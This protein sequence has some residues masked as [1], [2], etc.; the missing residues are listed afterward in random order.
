MLRKLA[1]SLALTSLAWAAPADDRFAQVAGDFLEGYLRNNPE[2]ATVLGDHRYDGDWSD[3][4]AA[5]VER[6]LAFARELLARLEALPASEL[7]RENAVDR[8]MLIH[9]LRGQ[10]WSTNELKEYHWNPLIY[11]PGPAI[12][13]IIAR[14]YAPLPQRLE[15]VASRLENLPT[16]LQQARAQLDNPPPIHCQTAIAQNTGTIAFLENDLE[17]FLKQAPEKRAR[18]E[19]A[20]RL[21]VQA[22]REYG[23]WLEKDL[24]PRSHGDFRLGRERWRKKLFFTLESSL[25]PEELQARAER[26][27]VRTHQEMTRVARPL[28]AQLLHRSADK[29]SDSQVCRAVLHKLAESRPD[30]AT[31]VPLAGE[32]LKKATAFVADHKLV[33]LPQEPCQIIEM[34]EFNRGVAIAYCDSPG[35]LEKG[36][37]TYYAIAPTP[38]DWS[39]ER[40]LSFYR[41]YNKAMLDDLTVHEAM[42]GHYLQL[43]HANRFQAPTKVR[44]ILQSGTFVEGWAT[45][46]EQ[47]MVANGYGGAPVHMQQLKMRLRLILNALLDQKVHAGHLS[48]AEG[49]RWLMQAGFQEEGEATAKWRRACLTSAQ[50]STYYVGNCEV[51]D[52]VTA[53]RKDHPGESWQS[54]HDQILAFG[55]PAPRYI[56]RL[57]KP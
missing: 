13:A 36:G 40:S 7:S 33:S 39:A 6:N 37:T 20:R 10:L 57:L 18:V 43:M 41:E 30:S 53:Y 22:L 44:A 16:F 26:D 9:S 29:L 52:L 24:L 49:V 50:L 51:N 56:A 1:L 42:P 45:Y 2:T 15:A 48:E 23:T 46:A 4:S 28:Y 54:V 32:S 14:D 8:D 21:A 3:V 47:M 35:P 17:E 25:T 5:G 55:S 19:A 34:P 38:S 31:I 12:F 27:L 11:N